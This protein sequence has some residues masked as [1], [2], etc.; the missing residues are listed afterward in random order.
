MRAIHAQARGVIRPQGQNRDGSNEAEL[1]CHSLGHEAWRGHEAGLD[2]EAWLGHEAAG[3]RSYDRSM[4][5]LDDLAVGAALEQL[6]EWTRD[7]D[8]IVR[9][10]K[11]RDWL[12]AI[13]LLNGIADEAQ[14]RDHHPDVCIEGYRRLTVRLTTHSE[15]GISKRD[16][17]LASWIEELAAAG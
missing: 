9:T 5:K 3:A 15:G 12:D 6:P 2:H 4:A 13:A 8:S 16:V 17:S 7:G 11:R 10:W 14:R 1:L